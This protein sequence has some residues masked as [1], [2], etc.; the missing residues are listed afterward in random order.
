MAHYSAAGRYELAGTWPHF[1]ASRPTQACELL[2][3]WDGAKYA[4]W[5]GLRPMSELEYEKACRG[6]RKP[7]A[8]EFAWGTPLVAV[9][10]YVA[11]NE[12]SPEERMRGGRGGPVGNATYD[13]TIPALYGGPSR[14]G[15][16]SAAG[17]PTRAGVF[18][19]PHSGRAAA[20]ASYWGIMDLS[21]NVCE[22]VVSVG[23]ER[24][25]VF[26]GTHGAGTTTPP[27]DWPAATYVHN[28]RGRVRFDEALGS[29]ARGGF[30]NST[31]PALRVSDRRLAVHR[32]F[33]RSKLSGW[34]GVRTAPPRRAPATVPVD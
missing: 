10:P 24:G 28:E 7:V 15:I 16:L 23:H 18:A 34:R 22:Q 31:H 8:N 29:G 30:F 3:W 17:G 4:A 21:G 19:T 11:E 1:R 27:E 25:R 9:D 14:I 5:A 33:T 26:A 6:P 12:G 32:V 2:S 20:G 13:S